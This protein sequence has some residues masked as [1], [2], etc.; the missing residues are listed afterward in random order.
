MSEWKMKRFW[1]EVT[2]KPVEG[3]FAIELDGRG[4]KTP[5]KTALIVPNAVLAERVAQE[6]RAV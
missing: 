6:W 1:S 5:A 3:G 4:V 2:P